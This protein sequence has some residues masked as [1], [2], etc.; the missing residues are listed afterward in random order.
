MQNPLVGIPNGAIRCK[1][2]P[3]TISGHVP[4]KAE[5][6]VSA[7]KTSAVSDKTS[8]VS[9]DKTSVVSLRDRPSVGNA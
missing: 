8:V 2:W 6:N 3:K 1:S 9:A 5:G 7:D 4:G